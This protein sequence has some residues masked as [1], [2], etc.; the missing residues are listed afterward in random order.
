MNSKSNEMQKPNE[1][2]NPRPRPDV[3]EV[4][5]ILTHSADDSVEKRG[6]L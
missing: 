2:S 4:M 5:K 1:S 6:I 3:S